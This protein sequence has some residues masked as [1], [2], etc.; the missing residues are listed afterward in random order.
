[1]TTLRPWV[2]AVSVLCGLTAAAATRIVDDDSPCP[3]SGSAADPYCSIQTA[4]DNAGTTG[5]TI[6]VKPGVYQECINTLVPASKT[7]VIQAE[8]PDPGLTVL[9]GTSCFSVSTVVTGAG[10]TLSGFRLTSGGEGA[11]A[12][13]GSVVITNNVIEGNVAQASGG[14][15]FADTAVEQY[16]GP[17]IIDIR[18][19]DNVIQGNSSERDGG[20]IWVS[21][22]SEGTVDATALV[23]GNTI[24]DNDAAGVGG[25]VGAF[26]DAGFG[27]TAALRITE[28]TLQSNDVT[29]ALGA[30]AD[31]FGG[32]IWV[33]T[34]GPGLE[35]IHIDHNTVGPALGSPDNS[36]RNTATR[37][38]RDLGP[39]FA[40]D[41]ADH[42]VFIE[43]N[44]VG[45]RLATLDARQDRPLR[46][47]RLAGPARQSTPQPLLGAHRRQRRGRQ[48]RRQLR[49]RRP[50]TWEQADRL[51]AEP[52][53]CRKGTGS[54]ATPRAWEAA[55]GM[56]VPSRRAVPPRSAGS[57]SATT[58]SPT[59][60]R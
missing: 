6:Q 58:R 26:T 51:P 11:I 9:D 46:A 24:K 36:L 22:R 44:V 56:R 25:G 2:L 31:G 8:D 59:T 57:R 37:T 47:R 48:Q 19:E 55:E 1:M 3:G 13:F 35:T 42:A 30:D 32:A 20:G 12:S 21:V 27:S 50:A 60:A 52:H 18:I 33:S 10:T 16:A 54:P 4:I 29:A 43:S 14:G 45:K 49:R 53:R 41:T 17:A 28:N 7:L 34:L 23:Q 39:V 38:G 40:V 15:I 5:D